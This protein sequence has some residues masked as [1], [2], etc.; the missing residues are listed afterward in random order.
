MND[1]IGMS[2]RQCF[3]GLHDVLDG[4]KD[5]ERPVIAH[6]LVEVLSLEMLHDD[7]RRTVGKRANVEDTR[8]VLAFDLH[9]GASFARETTHQLLVGQRLATKELESNLL[10]ELD[11]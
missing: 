1:S 11:V 6:R 3:A 9:R 2:D 10:A 8:H 4:E 7:E 5:R